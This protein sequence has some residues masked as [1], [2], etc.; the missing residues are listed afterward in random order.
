[1][2][3]IFTDFYYFNST[4]S[5]NTPCNPNP[6]SHGT[7][8]SVVDNPTIK[9]YKCDCTGTP[10][11]GNE[12]QMIRTRITGIPIQIVAGQETT[13]IRFYA[14][15]DNFVKVK[16]SS[17]GDLSFNPPEI[18]ISH[19][20]SFGEFKIIAEKEGK[21]SIEYDI[22]GDDQSKTVT[23]PATTIYVQDSKSAS[24][25]FQ[26]VNI[27]FEDILS[28]TASCESYN[29]DMLCKTTTRLQY[30][31]SCSFYKRGLI[32]IESATE[33][34]VKFP[35]T[36]IGLSG[37]ELHGKKYIDPLLIIEDYI[38]NRP[39]M[40]CTSSCDPNTIINS[41]TFDYLVQFGYYPRYLL[42]RFSKIFGEWIE[43][44]QA[45]PAKSSF[46]PRNLRLIVGDGS[47]IKKQCPGQ[48]LDSD[49]YYAAYVPEFP[50]NLKVLNSKVQIPHICITYNLCRD[51]LE[52]S[53]IR[54]DKGGSN[55]NMR[56][57][58]NDI[59]SENI[60][61]KD[62]E[63]KRMISYQHDGVLYGKVIEI[64][65]S[66]TFQIGQTMHMKL[67]GLYQLQ[68]KVNYLLLY[69]RAIF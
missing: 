22:S 54:G 56:N 60:V 69:Q 50:V 25:H 62:L 36:P 4:H 21:Y 2:Y 18:T 40:E 44:T 29:L 8:C 42:Q 19:L 30:Q 3:H 11:Q 64:D 15:P 20:S 34:V 48:D 53:T 10:Y 59:L 65:A 51:K 12:C 31:S 41:N 37:V 7:Y 27:T 24:R 61:L 43:I 35:L 14:K 28:Q 38:L 1:M 47:K 46:S 58:V 16:L 55:V 32:S 67:D 13:P 49:D 26:P 33:A 66:M 52:L 5:A 9:N 63:L 17:S 45:I 6:C 68:R 39:S 23:P 57:I